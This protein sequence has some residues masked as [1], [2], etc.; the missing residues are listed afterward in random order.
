[1]NVLKDIIQFES[2]WQNLNRK[3]VKMWRQ[4]IL[5]QMVIKIMK[6]YLIVKSVSIYG[7][8]CKKCFCMLSLRTCLSSLSFLYNIT[9]IFFKSSSKISRKITVLPFHNI[10][11]WSRSRY[12]ID[13]SCN[14]VLN[15]HDPLCYN[16]V[17]MLP[18]CKSKFTKMVIESPL[19]SRLGHK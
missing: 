17:T 12:G 5:R 6:K 10:T 3:N 2:P 14:N 15:S 16:S 8:V 13:L 7:M 18:S 11:R 1:M 9:F 4:N 19:C